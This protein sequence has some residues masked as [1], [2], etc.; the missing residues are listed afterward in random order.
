MVQSPPCPACHFEIYGIKNLS[1]KDITTDDEK[2]FP[3]IGY[4]ASV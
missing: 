4:T 2:N 1:N 3:C